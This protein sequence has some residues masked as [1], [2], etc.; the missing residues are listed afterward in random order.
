MKKKK[1]SFIKTH[2]TGKLKKKKYILSYK[3]GKKKINGRFV[4]KLQSCYSLILN[5]FE[6]WELFEMG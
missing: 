3:E 6:V 2:R 5:E 4:K 1:T